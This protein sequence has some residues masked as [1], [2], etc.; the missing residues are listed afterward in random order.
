M[1]SAEQRSLEY[2]DRL[3]R[4]NRDIAQVQARA[5]R[6]LRKQLYGGYIM[7][8]CIDSRI[9]FASMMD[10]GEGPILYQ[11]NSFA[12]SSNIDRL[13]GRL[14]QHD[15][16]GVVFGSHWDEEEDGETEMG[17]GGCGARRAKQ[18]MQKGETM[19]ISA[20][21]YIHDNVH[22]HCI[23]G[24]VTQ[25]LTMS[26]HVAVPCFALGMSHITQEPHLI[27]AVEQGKFTYQVGFD[28][29]R[30][31][32]DQ[33]IPPD[34]QE[35]YPDIMAMLQ[36]GR[37]FARNQTPEEMQRRKVQDPQLVWATGSHYPT[38]DV[39]GPSLGEIMRIGYYRDRNNKLR[40]GELEHLEDHLS[41]PF[42]M[43]TEGSHGFT[44][45][46]ALMIDGKQKGVYHNIWE[47]LKEAS[48]TKLWLESGDRVVMGAVVRAGNVMSYE[49]LD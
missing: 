33:P 49:R 19:H 3:V 5:L 10:P 43:A 34:I 14:Y 40:N 8:S 18:R 38:W 1:H 48:E 23:E 17:Y 4:A 32:S 6:H 36:Q 15:T 42:H 25:A 45:T 44:Q 37:V 22:P 13:V 21:R 28:E 20:A 26:N 16:R 2:I 47:R 41:Y 29:I 31:R 46:N 24:A 9:N 30:G 27:A 7:G 35:R 39:F 12:G 11:V